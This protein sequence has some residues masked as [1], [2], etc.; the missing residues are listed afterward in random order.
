[1]QVVRI[2]YDGDTVFSHSL[3]ATQIPTRNRTVDS[4]LWI[5]AASLKRFSSRHVAARALRD[6]I[7][8]SRHYPAVTQVIGGDDGTTWLRLG[9]A[10]GAAQRWLG[11][12]RNGSIL[13]QVTLPGRARLLLAR[14]DAVWIEEAD[15]L[16]VPSIAQLRLSTGDPGT[17]H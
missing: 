13:A 12:A 3:P 11:L 1:V 8:I 14:R 7:T 16:G 10:P 5:E 15:E 4:L 2:G 6:A 9:G 17:H